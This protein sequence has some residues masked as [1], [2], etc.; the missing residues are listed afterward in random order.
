MRQLLEIILPIMGRIGIAKYIVL[1]IVTGLSSFLFINTVTRVIGIMIEGNFTII[2]KEYIVIFSSIILLFIWSRRALSLY[3]VKTSLRISWSLRMKI[4]SEVLGSGYRQLMVRKTR[5]YTAIR[6]D[7]NAL[8]NASMS[9]IDFII[10]I[11]IAFSCCV[12]LA[13]ISL[14]LFSITLTFAILGVAVYYFSAKA[15]MQALEKSHSLES[16]FQKGF[17][18]ILDGFKEIYIDPSK[19]KFIYDMRI[20]RTARDSYDHN[21][22][23]VTGFINNQVTGQILFYIHIASVLLIFSVILDINASRVVSFLFTLL[24]LLG[25]LETIMVHIPTMM[26]AKVASDHLMKLKNELAEE[27]AIKEAQKSGVFA[28]SFEELTVSNLQFVY[29]E[30]SFQVGPVNFVIKK[31]EIVFIYGGNGSG[32]T[33]LIQCILGLCTL[34]KGEVVVNGITVTSENQADYKNLFAVV[35]SDFYL[36]DE[37][38]NSDPVDQNK[39]SYYIELFELGEVVVL[40]ED[41]RFSTTDLSSG[42][43]KRLALVVALLEQKPILVLD[44]WAADQD[45]YFRNKFYTRILP[46]L[47]REGFTIIAITHDDKY[48]AYSNKLF[49]MDGGILQDESVFRPVMSDF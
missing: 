34:R 8:T 43:R 4:L 25:S 46:S 7:V 38:C 1:G 28:I 10:A 21:M 14:A 6:H 5:I 37:M 47:Q 11:I 19:G 16:E 41:G 42:Q 30:S 12:Y 48:Y 39:W 40:Q 24:Y 18:S 33:T 3:S 35:F 36:F 32:K 2:S 20:T 23:A 29:D 45:P 13:S 27:D 26:R 49:K 17:N 31:G 44:E 9:M 15:N 22:F